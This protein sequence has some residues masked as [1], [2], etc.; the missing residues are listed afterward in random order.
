M[1]SHSVTSHGVKNLQRSPLNG[2]HKSR[3]AKR[4]TDHKISV[5]VGASSYLKRHIDVLSALAAPAPVPTNTVSPVAGEKMDV[6]S[7]GGAS[8]S[9][10]CSSLSQGQSASGDEDRRGD[11]AVLFARAVA[12]VAGASTS[13]TPRDIF[14]PA[15]TPAP[16]PTPSP[17]PS[18]SPSS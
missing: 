11:L 10:T 18:P 2:L 4:K 3:V 14:T 6:D 9:E 13:W 8:V 5:R 16:T 7:E 12:L 1:T 15:P 17:S